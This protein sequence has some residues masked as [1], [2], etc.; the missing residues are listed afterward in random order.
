MYTRNV[1]LYCKWTCIKFVV[2]AWKL[3]WY[4]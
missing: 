2:V 4:P 3:L 1:V